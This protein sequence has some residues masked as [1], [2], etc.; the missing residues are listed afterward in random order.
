MFFLLF[1]LPAIIRDSTKNASEVNE[2]PIAFDIIWDLFDAKDSIDTPSL[3]PSLPPS[4]PRYATPI[5]TPEK[6]IS[7][8]T[9]NKSGTEDPPEIITSK[10]F[11]AKRYQIVPYIKVFSS[12]F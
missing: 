7:T 6:V 8:E 1:I 9:V 5:S 3:P 11:T 12:H 4:F 2:K 10:P